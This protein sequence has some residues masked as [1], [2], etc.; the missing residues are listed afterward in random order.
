MRRRSFLAAGFAPL[1]GA[2]TDKKPNIVLVLMD[3]MGQGCFPPYAQKLEV[4]DFD[5]AFVAAMKE[6]KVALVLQTKF[7]I[8]QREEHFVEIVKKKYL[9]P[10]D[11]SWIVQPLGAHEKRG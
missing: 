7:P 3:D 9:E 6:K 8:T 10:R 11:I 2:A 1:L 5:P 4:K